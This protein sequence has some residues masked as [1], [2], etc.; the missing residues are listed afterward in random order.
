L[1][2]KRKINF[3][4]QLHLRENK[5]GTKILIITDF[6]EGE[7]WGV[8]YKHISWFIFHPIF[9]LKR[10]NGGQT[11]GEI[12]VYIEFIAARLPTLQILCEKTSSKY[13]K[14]NTPFK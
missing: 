9:I 4:L 5:F 14:F 2:L 11:G 1:L 6:G 13:L 10:R 12:W 8:K 7:H 3:A